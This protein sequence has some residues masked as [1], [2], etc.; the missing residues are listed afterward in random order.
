MLTLRA[1]IAVVCL[2]VISGA[3]GAVDM[4]APIRAPGVFTPAPCTLQACSGFYVGV[5]VIGAGANTDLTIAPGFSSSVFSAGGMIG[6]QA[7]YQFWNGK[8]FIA[9]EAGID[10]DVTNNIQVTAVTNSK[11]YFAFQVVKLGTALFDLGG[12]TSPTQAPVPIS[13][14]S[15]LASMLISPYV[16]TGAV[17]RPWGTGWAYGAGADFIVGSGWNLDLSYLRVTYGGSPSINPVTIEK[18]ENLI[19]IGFNRKF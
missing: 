12:Q 13:I 6:M 3:A 17:E 1:M 7:G 9:A 5:N 16:Q 15:S 4:P 8:W 11:R 2:A 18:S 19:K 14:P 10:Y